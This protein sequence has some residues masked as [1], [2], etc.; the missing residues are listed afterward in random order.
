MQHD[1]AKAHVLDREASIEQ[2]FSVR[3]DARTS[4]DRIDANERPAL[5]RAMRARSRIGWLT[6]LFCTSASVLCLEVLNTRL[7][8]V[9]VWYHLSFFVVSSAMFGL[10][11]GALRVYLGGARFTDERAEPALRRAAALFALSIPICHVAVVLLPHPTTV[12]IQA[13]CAFAAAIVLLAIPFYWA[14]FLVTLVLTR[15]ASRI[16]TAYAVDLVGA[17]A[18]A[19]IAV[20]LLAISDLSTA[21]FAAGALA[22]LGFVGFAHAST[23]RVSVAALIVLV[24][25]IA[26]TV[27]NHASADRVR[28]WYP[29]GVFLPTTE[30]AEESWNIDSQVVV[31]RS[32]LDRPHYWGP[33]L[34]SEHF[35]VEGRRIAIDGGAETVVTK[36][37]G[38]RESLAWTEFDVTAL[39]Y[40]LR[41][42]G[43]VAIVGCGG[44][45]D[46]LTALRARATKV[47]AIEVNGA[48]VDLLEGSQRSFAGLA[49]RSDVEL[50]HAE[51]RGHLAR[52]RERF[53]VVQ[54]SLIDTWAATGAGAL[55]LTEN[56]L[57]T[58]EGWDVF[59]G[60]L[61][62]NGVFGVSRWYDPNSV[63]ET[64]RLVSLA[65]GALLRAGVEHPRDHLA[66]VACGNV[67]TLI[68]ARDRLGTVGVATIREAA[69]RYDFQLLA[70]PSHHA[71]D[72]GIERILAAT[73]MPELLVAAQ[74]ERYDFTPPTDDRPY[75]FNQL[76][77]SAA[78]SM[79]PR[80]AGG[81]VVQGNL[82]ATASL[83]VL[84]G[85]SMLL[86]VGAL[87]VPLLRFA[88]RRTGVIGFVPAVLYFAAIGL[89]YM[90]V[91]VALVQRFSVLL[92][93]PAHS[94]V[95]TLTTMIVASSVGSLVS[96]RLKVEDRPFLLRAIPMA[97]ALLLAVVA[98]SIQSIVA[99]AIEFDFARRCLVTVAV[100]AP[101]SLLLGVAF[102]I[103][104]RL[105][106]RR[107]DHILPWAIGVNGA[108]SVLATVLAVGVSIWWGIGTNL[109]IAAGLYA[110]LAISAPVLAQRARA[111]EA[112]AVAV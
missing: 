57:Y 109:W 86:V 81:G 104:V 90:F 96:V 112:P 80:D 2:S 102:P 20:P 41:P 40:S 82:E 16:G 74:N 49:G 93:Q 4:A 9:A 100:V 73:T 76:K 92:G 83:Q 108:C 101:P 51:A 99:S 6:G 68:V 110:S 50:V 61:A 78:F 10:S 52:S 97:I 46:V 44:G 91:Q 111:G 24:G 21:V 75:F 48:L 38:R 71:R 70:L 8:S 15:F 94:I 28:V 5:L 67:A 105:V 17:A 11:A 43:R 29:K 3:A 7:Y 56:G 98:L 85:I 1:C 66:L 53:D 26:A 25:S 106:H 58:L 33:G 77:A 19:L 89:G 64:S 54:M 95:V 47:E 27:A 35:R 30:I 84:A 18:G 45:R 63:S 32:P 69:E 39:P 31:Y 87:C 22:A 103:G 12:G 79:S 36:W 72:P 65:V 37:D 55:T 88:P 107:S 42:G 23:G 34:A 60:V 14:G 59:L 13:T 62:P